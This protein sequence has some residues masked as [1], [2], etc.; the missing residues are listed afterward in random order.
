MSHNYCVDKKQKW[1]ET[2]LQRQT[3]LK[4][5]DREFSI[6]SGDLQRIKKIPA[7]QNAYFGLSE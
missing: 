3:S 2:S 6:L 5:W 1:L 4:R 7:N